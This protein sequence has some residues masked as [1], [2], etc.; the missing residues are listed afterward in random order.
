VFSFPC[1]Y[2]IEIL[3][4]LCC[5]LAL[6][7]PVLAFRFGDAQRFGTC[8]RVRLTDEAVARVDASRLVIRVI[9]IDGR[10]FVAVG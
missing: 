7:N 9:G 1:D 6:L 5:F 10:M 3:N 2:P 4:Y 8:F